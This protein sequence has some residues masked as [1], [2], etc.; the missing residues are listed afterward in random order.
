MLTADLLMAKSRFQ[1]LPQDVQ[2]ALSDAARASARLERQL[3]AESDN[4]LLEILETRGV[5]VTYPDAEP[6]RDASRTVYEKF[7]TSESDRKLLDDILK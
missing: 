6:F 2:V 1:S 7:V 4:S 5:T 3:Y